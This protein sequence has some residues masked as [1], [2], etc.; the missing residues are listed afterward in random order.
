MTAPEHKRNIGSGHV[1]YLDGWR[2]LAILM[3]MV[4]HFLP[5]PGISFGA[6]GVNLF[7]VLS[8]LLMGG[9][10]FEKQEPI[11]KFYR[12]RIARI[13]PAHLVFVLV[14]T[15]AYLLM[16]H[17]ISLREIAAALLFVNNYCLPE[18]GPGTALMPF[19]HIWSLSVEEHSYI[20]L[21]LVA[22]ASRRGLMSA[23]AGAGFLLA[24]CICFAVGYQILNP[25]QL[26]FVQWLHTEV[27]AYG[28]MASAAWVAA[29]RRW[30]GGD[31][32]PAFVAPALVLLGIGLHWWS[33]PLAVQRILGVGC[34]VA[35][36][37]LLTAHGGW[38]ATL[39]E[40]APLRQLGLWSY[41]LYLWQ[42]PFY[43][44]SHRE[45]GISPY[46]ALIAAL[47]AGLLSYYSVERP[48]RSYLN[49]HWG[50]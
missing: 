26:A 19:G 38:F 41:S 9:L 30:A 11:A 42:Q 35:A 29:G 43:L 10:L 14:M 34:F 49:A 17:P 23:G 7:F 22:I 37:C 3:L 18:G 31:R 46:L 5:V 47:A 25:P 6:V 24:T 39:L 21:S 40:W 16:G 20:A 15:L 50:R 45:N 8:G 32:L 36:L 4:G 2:G 13:L 27:A 33:L 12:R 1:D 44:L 48:L 28:L